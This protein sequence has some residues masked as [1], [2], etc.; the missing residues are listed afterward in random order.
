M[1]R[2]PGHPGGTSP[3]AIVVTMTEEVP[4]PVGNEGGLTEQVV[5]VAAT[6]RA[7]VK[8]TCAEKLFCGAMV[9]TFEN[10]AGWPAGTVSVV[11]P[12]EVIVKSGGPVTVKLKGA[13]VPAGAGSTTYKAYEP[14]PTGV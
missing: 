12:E 5:A 11:V 14:V 7:Q 8:L 1:K 6:G 13:E 4:L 2:I 9:S 10:V 3:R